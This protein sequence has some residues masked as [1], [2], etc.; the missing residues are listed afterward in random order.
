MKLALVVSALWAVASVAVLQTAPG[1]L[2]LT[3]V[4]FYVLIGAGLPSGA[5]LIN[6][7]QLDETAAPNWIVVFLMTIAASFVASALGGQP[8]IWTAQWTASR[9]VLATMLVGMLLSILAER[10][11]RREVA[12]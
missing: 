2:V 10:M 3:I 11:T 4:L 12:P 7:N 8:L 5:A 6:W 9:H 1:P